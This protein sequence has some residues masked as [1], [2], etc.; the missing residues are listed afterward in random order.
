M[1]TGLEGGRSFSIPV[2]FPHEPNIRGW[3]ERKDNVVITE[4]G[5]KE[6]WCPFARVLVS[7]GDR[8]ND[9]VSLSDHPTTS[10]NRRLGHEDAAAKC[11]GSGCMLWDWEGTPG[12]NG[13]CGLGRR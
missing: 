11:I 10:G 13:Y 2:P 7:A 4:E 8:S 3:N 12:V 9:V 1:R 6:K 5:A